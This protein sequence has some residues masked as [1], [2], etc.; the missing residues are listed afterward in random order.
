MQDYLSTLPD[1]YAKQ[2]L[3][4]RLAAAGK[5]RTKPDFP[6]HDAKT[7]P[8]RTRLIGADEPEAI[9]HNRIFSKL[10]FRSAPY[11]Y[12]LLN[13]PDEYF[14]TSHTTAAVFISRSRFAQERT[15][16]E[17]GHLVSGKFDP[18][19]LDYLID[20]AL[21]LYCDS[22]SAGFYGTGKI[23]TELTALRGNYQES[24]SQPPLKKRIS[25][26]RM[27]SKEPEFMA[28]AADQNKETNDALQDLVLRKGPSFL[29]R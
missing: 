2:I 8:Y 23:T 22:F 18:E 20:Q 14:C 3:T 6:E 15:G 1:G 10:G 16:H 25:F 12:R 19:T 7:L 13:A 9:E 5:T 4:Q 28:F 17:I 24:P 21:E 11:L 26:I 29:E 27:C